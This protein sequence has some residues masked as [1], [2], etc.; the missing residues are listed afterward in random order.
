MAALFVAMMMQATGSSVQAEGAG[1]GISP[2]QLEQ[3]MPGATRIGE[4]TGNPAAAPAYRDGEL[5]GYVFHSREVV[6]SVGYSGKPLDVLVGLDLDARI[7][8]ATI[9]EQHEPILV[10]GPCRSLVRSDRHRDRPGLP[11]LPP[12]PSL[13]RRDDR[14]QCGDGQG[15]QSPPVSQRRTTIGFLRRQPELSAEP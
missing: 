3:A 8:G 6:Q 2:E 7:T 10:I 14:A 1:A 5:I 11:G 12:P 13:E 4:A 15:C 9:L